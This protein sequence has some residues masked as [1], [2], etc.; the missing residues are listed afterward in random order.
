MT[1]KKPNRFGWF[2]Q[3]PLG[4]WGRKL[5]FRWVFPIGTMPVP[6]HPLVFPVAIALIIAW[7][8]RSAL[9]PVAHAV[10]PGWPGMLFAAGLLG[11]TMSVP[12]LAWAVMA[13]GGRI[14]QA[15]LILC[16]MVVLA[17]Q[18]MAG[19]VTIWLS[20]IPAAYFGLWVVLFVVG[21]VQKRRLLAGWKAFS[22]PAITDQPV[23]LGD[24]FT[25]GTPYDILN[26]YAIADLWMIDRDDPASGRGCYRLDPMSLEAVREIAG[27]A[28]PEGWQLT[29]HGAFSMLERKGQVPSDA[30][31]LTST[32]WKASLRALAPGLLKVTVDD[33]VCRSLV[34]G[35]VHTIALLPLFEAFH[36]TAI[37]GGQ[38]HWRIGYVY[39]RGKWIGKLDDR[40]A[41]IVT[42]PETV[43]PLP[44]ERLAA[45]RDDLAA[46]V[47]SRQ[48]A[49][50]AFKAAVA[51]DPLGHSVHKETVRL[52]QSAGSDPLGPDAGPFLLDWL[53][54]A[55]D[56]R[57]R[58]AVA[59]AAGLIAKLSDDAFAALAPELFITL[60]SRKLALEWKLVPGFD[61]APLPKETP[62]F[63]DRGGFGLIFTN[64]A[65]YVRLGEVHPPARDLIAELAKEM[66]L[67]KPAMKAIERW[68]GEE[69]V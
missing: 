51:S 32:P 15:V 41:G 56:G 54:R 16:A 29:N 13:L 60:N 26:R 4:T 50:A 3:G 37:F 8:I 63:G 31:R 61:P 59:I 19:K 30:V 28:M 55:R 42:L 20:V 62:R 43:M 68:K 9:T 11:L 58:Y 38:R 5:G 21:Q 66:D 10:G 48:I 33:G 49:V 2:M 45:L 47:A 24:N 39:G 23:A 52:L 34:W 18:A 69:T 22:P 7:G 25:W 12:I 14:I 40:L 46:A 17:A 53:H 1:G 64:S 67:P 27:A 44:A 6:F 65:L 35:Q 36:W 57:K